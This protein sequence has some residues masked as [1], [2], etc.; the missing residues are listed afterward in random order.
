MRH[1][2]GVA[3]PS[4]TSDAAVTVGTA[5]SLVGV[6][7]RTLHHWDEIGL[8][9]PSE[10]SPAGY[11]LYAPSDLARLHQVVVHR[12]LGVSLEET[13]RLLEAPAEEAADAL[14]RQSDRLRERITR[15]EG[16]AGA[17]DRM[18]EARESGLLLSAEDQV[19][20]FGERW[21]PD[22]SEQA[23]RKWG[24][25]AQWAQYTERAAQRT[26][27][28]WRRITAD[29][30]ALNADLI[31]AMRAGVEPGSERADTLAEQH[32]ASIGVYFHC[33]HSMQVLIGRTYAED[34][35]FRENQ[36]ALA[37]GLAQWLHEVIDANARRHGVD[38]A[39]ATWE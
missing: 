32:R 29:V 26:T 34:P 7:V 39:T 30:E 38:P 17:L 20:I 33:T 21:N 35:A 11:R 1:T 2:E 18:A 12:E 5:A 19:A 24:H 13:A 16:L 36:E 9:H 23:R 6:T 28:D 31:E 8:V 4:G 15:L 3:E 27:E 14:L 10:R 25:T 37:P 22:W